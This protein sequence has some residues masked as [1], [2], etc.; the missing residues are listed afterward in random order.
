MLARRV[1]AEGRTRAYLSG[2]SLGVGGAARRSPA[3]CS[4]STA[5]TSTASS[6]SRPPS[7]TCSTAS[8]APTRPSAGSALRGG[9][10]DGRASCAPRSRTCRRA[11]GA[12]DREL[13]LLEF[14][15]AEIEEAAP[16]ETEEARAAR[17]ARAAAPPRGPAGGRARRRRGAGARVGRAPARASCSPAADARARGAARASTPRS[18]A[19]PSGCAA[20]AL[21][22]RGPRRRA[23]RATSRR[24]RASPAASRRSRSGWR[25]SSVSSASTAA[26]SPPSSRTPSAAARAAT[27][28]PAPRRRSSARRATW[29]RPRRSWRGCAGALGQGAPGGGAA[30]GRGGARAARGAGDGG[31][32]LRGRGSTARDEPGPTGAETVEFRIAPNPGVPAGPLREIASGGELS[33]VML[34]LMGVAAEGRTA[35]RPAARPTR[36]CSCST[37]STPASAGTPRAPWASACATWRAGRQVL[38]ITHLPQ[39]ASLADRHFRIEKDTGADPARATVEELRPDARRGRARPHARRR[40]GDVGRKPPREGAPQGGVAAVHF[41]RVAVSGTKRE[42]AAGHDRSPCG[43]MSRASPGWGSGPSISSSGCAAATSR[44][45]ITSTSTG[46]RPRT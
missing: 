10:G 46:S 30:A 6:R 5:S 27:S 1:S 11:R 19:S 38:C 21:R 12:R 37:R 20:A 29:P 24:S 40:R 23:A 7:S 34:A 17:R 45:S 42:P 9:L 26:R 41:A 13:D 18:T 39:V 22:A 4:R 2:R 33:R 28:W 14:E 31:R 43:E 3:A 35:G 15:L 8:A 44:S 36:R 25:R 16:N 32:R